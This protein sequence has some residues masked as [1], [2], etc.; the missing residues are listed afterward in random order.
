MNGAVP[1]LSL[2]TSA[3]WKEMNLSLHQEITCRDKVGIGDNFLE[4]K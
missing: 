4:L 1:L 2:H 3:V